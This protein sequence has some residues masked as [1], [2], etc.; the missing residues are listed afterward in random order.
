MEYSARNI[1]LRVFLIS[2]PVFFVWEMLQMPYYEGMGYG[3]LQSW[4]GCFQA[5]LGDAVIVL[6][7][8]V[9]GRLVFGT[10]TWAM[11]YT[12]VRLLFLMAA[13][14]LV[15]LGIEISAHILGRWSY[16]EAMPVV[17]IAGYP[18]GLVAVAQMLIL[19]WLSMRLALS[20]RLSI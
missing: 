11:D 8:L 3:D 9:A 15:I 2:I 16:S 17:H 6:G 13:G 10:W 1:L 7:I 18:L 4:V 20:E 14:L 5:S 12:P 19:P